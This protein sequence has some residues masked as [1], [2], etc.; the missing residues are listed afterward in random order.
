[1]TN[2]VGG[3]KE[4]KWETQCVG[5]AELKVATVFVGVVRRP[6]RVLQVGARQL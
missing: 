4:N 6:Y 3:S 1:M 2:L 5:V